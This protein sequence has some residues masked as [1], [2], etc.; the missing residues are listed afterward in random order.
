M[1][2]GVYTSLF[3][4][5]TIG[6]LVSTPTLAQPS[7]TASPDGMNTVV[8]PNG[9]TLNISGGTQSGANLFHSFQQFGLTQAQTANF[10]SN[11]AIQNILGRV[12]G[13]NASIIN[14]I[15]RVSGSNANLFLMN[16]AGIVFGA[17]ASLNVPD[18]FVATTAN[19][20]GFGCSNAG[21]TGYFNAVG[22]NDFSKL[23]GSVGGYIFSGTQPGSIINAGN[24]NVPGGQSLML[25]GGTVV[26]NGTLSAPSGSVTVAAIRGDQLVRVT[27]PGSL[28][29]L[30]LPLSVKNQ[31]NP[32]SFNPLSL[33]QLLTG[34]N[35]G[36]ATGLTVQNGEVKLIGSN[37]LVPS[38]AGDVTVSKQI[39]VSSVA[40]GTV[41]I[42]GDRVNLTGATI[43]ASGTDGGGQ[44]L[45]GGDFQGKGTLPT[46]DRTFVS[47][48]S[49]ID[50]SALTRGDGGRVIVWADQTT[51]FYG[52]IQA[53]GG[54]L[55]GNGGFV[56][57]SGKENL[58]Y[59]GTVDVSAANGS[60]GTLLLDPRN[61]TI[62]DG[63]AGMGADDAQ[64]S[65]GEILV[66]DGGTADFVLSKSALESLTGTVVLEATDNIT[67]ADGVSLI[68]SN[69]NGITFTADADGNGV[70]SFVMSP[71]EEIRTNGGSATISGAR[72]I[73][74]KINTFLP[75]SNTS[76][77]IADDLR[78]PAA[79]G[80]VVISTLGDQSIQRILGRD[81]T[82]T[83]QNGNIITG[84]LSSEAEYFG[85]GSHVRL[86]APKG[87]VLLQGFI[88]VGQTNKSTDSTITIGCD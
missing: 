18:S 8:T 4:L 22:A 56:E 84:S 1:K 50:A 60:N 82:L 2:T 83:S 43:H 55:R 42:L 30:D 68:F 75:G 17:N 78:F 14:G 9:N 64:L 19:A 88:R 33:P 12:T 45:I 58:A 48:D 34:G 11:P 7:I 39:N 38:N 77:F 49:T 71:T 16:P 53:K 80:S 28:L 57:V 20:I 27:Q 65:D 25:L 69:L 47:A 74:G 5:L 87:S 6:L 32:L 76:N 70:G 29:S 41:T 81:I 26:N 51:G 73:V 10:L 62:V 79:S 46:A 61:I 21:C 59:Q 52:K 63:V 35:V 72:A 40:G 85:P 37:A 44:V 86:F 3:P 67:I 15:I 36:N 23:S 13:G 24:L 66:G 54:A 31:V